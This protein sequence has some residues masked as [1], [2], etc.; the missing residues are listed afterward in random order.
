MASAELSRRFEVVGYPPLVEMSNLQRCDFHEA[1]LD[2]DSFEDLPR[3]W[4]AAIPG[5]DL[6][7][8]ALDP[9]RFQRPDFS[10]ALGGRR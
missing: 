4:Q 8:L 1:L 5:L 2:A 3:K 10:K 9:N 7:R 6:H